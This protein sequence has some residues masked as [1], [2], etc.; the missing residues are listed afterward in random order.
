MNPSK[1]K[2]TRAEGEVLRWLADVTG[3]VCLHRNVQHGAHDIGDIGGLYDADNKPIVI[4]VKACKT[5]SL[6]EWLRELDK[7]RA[8][9][10]ARWGFIV[11]RTAG[12]TN[13]DEW[14]VITN[15]MGAAS[16]VPG[17]ASSLPKYVR[18]AC[19]FAGPKIHRHVGFRCD[20][21]M[22]INSLDCDAAAITGEAFAWWLVNCR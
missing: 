14:I 7:E 13:P 17:P 19:H 21:Q 5:P 12:T 6:R 20:G 3:S 11:W 1:A 4:E 2:G 18:A 8:N 15:D 9:A 16:A 10:N 22:P